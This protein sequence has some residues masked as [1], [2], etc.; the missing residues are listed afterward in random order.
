[1]G[2]LSFLNLYSNFPSI[3]KSR[4]VDLRDRCRSS[5]LLLHDALPWFI[6]KT[7]PEYLLRTPAS[8]VFPDD[9]LYV[10]PLILR[11][12]VEHPSEHLLKLWREDCTLHRYSLP[13]F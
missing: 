4:P 13:N 11:R 8:K 5:S 2:N 6:G 12:I 3:C 10:T 9:L 1:M 7:D